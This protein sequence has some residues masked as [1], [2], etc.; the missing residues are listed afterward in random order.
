MPKHI[1]RHGVEVPLDVVLRAFEVTDLWDA[2]DRQIAMICAVMEEM[3]VPRTRIA[4][5]LGMPY[6]IL[7]LKKRHISLTDHKVITECAHRIAASWI[8]EATDLFI[9]ELEG[10]Q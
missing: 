4:Q 9:A 8:K 5:I 1:V 10:T 7:N 3:G 2:D 6:S